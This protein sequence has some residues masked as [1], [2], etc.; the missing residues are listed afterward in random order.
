MLGLIPYGVGALL[1]WPAVIYRSFGE[2]CG[3]TFIIGFGLGTFGDYCQ[4]LP[5]WYN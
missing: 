5:R 1:F 2:F 3:S 4:P